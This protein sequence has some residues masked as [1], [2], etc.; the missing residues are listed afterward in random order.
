MFIFD[1]I[2]T[3]TI[4]G[5]F[6]TK[7]GQSIT[8]HWGDGT[9]NTYSGTTDKAYSHDYG[10]VSTHR[11]TV[12]NA[13]VMTKFTMETTDANIKF[14]LSSLPSGLTYFLC[15][16]S[17]TIT[18]NL[19]SLPSGLTYFRCRGYNTVTGNLSS[20]PSGLTYFRCDGSNTVTDYTSKT[21]TTKPATFT[22][23]PVAGGGLD[24]S[25]IDQLLVDLDDDL[26]W[27]S[28]N[29][30][31]LTGTNAAPSATGIA[32]KNHILSEGAAVTTT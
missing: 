5:V 22:L 25:E 28:G 12:I 9:L 23:I 8:V 7:A 11:V 16:G 3:Q 30:I 24:Q 14:D 20:L 26:T 19:S 1:V 4:A 2:S 6:Q 13:G 15:D 29:A 17:N 21:W 18:G 32:A 31:T 10:S 27:A